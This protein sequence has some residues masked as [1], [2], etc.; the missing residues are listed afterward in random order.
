[1]RNVED[2]K[3][4]N[5]DRSTLE[6]L[7][8]YCVT[9][10]VAFKGSQREETLK[11][12]LR[13][14]FNMDGEIIGYTG[15]QRTIKPRN[16]VVP[17]M[18]LKPNGVWGGKRHR[19][20]VS[21]PSLLSRRDEAMHV[22]SNGHYGSSDVRGYPIRFGAWV[23]V[24][25]PIFTRVCEIEKAEVHFMDVPIEIDGAKSHDVVAVFKHENLYTVEVDNRDGEPGYQHL[26]ANTMEWYRD[27]R[28]DWYASLD[29]RE[30]Q[31]VAKYLGLATK[32]IGEKGKISPDIPVE[33][34]RENIY[35]HVFGYSDPLTE[36]ELEELQEQE[37]EAA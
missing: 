32:D 19:I 17:P 12:I 9:E 16:Q 35:Q 31:T 21:K 28:V 36:A 26:P 18:N 8:N 2:A 24:P 3:Q 20:R 15:K 6:E 37:K 27:K 11:K 34:L 7:R 5:F 1:M 13:A 30:L 4:I 23:V 14:H 22:I 10:K 29:V 25:T 33:R